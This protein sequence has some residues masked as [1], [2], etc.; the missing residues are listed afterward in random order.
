M[1]MPRLHLSVGLSL[2]AGVLQL[3]AAEGG[4]K[5]ESRERAPNTSRKRRPSERQAANVFRAYDKN[6]DG[7]VTVDEWLAIRHL[8][9]SDKSDRARV[10]R[11]RF[12]AAGPGSDNRM[13]QKE[14][15]FWYTQGRFNQLREGGPSAEAGAP[16]RGPR[17]GEGSRP[18]GPR[19]GEGAPRKGPRDGEGAPRRGPGDTGAPSAESRVVTIKADAN[20]RMIGGERRL[21]DSKQTRTELRR[22]AATANGRKVVI[23]AEQG[24]S[25]AALQSLMR[26]CQAAGI[27]NLFI[28]TR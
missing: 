16:R 6:R 1:K 11:T 20:G 5:P 14:F 4:F 23:R 26:E 27:K 13:S 24:M 9:P 25:A 17:D 3:P 28:S 7:A 19:D 15:I 10:E 21:L 18:A 22:I 8:S 2:L 12:Q